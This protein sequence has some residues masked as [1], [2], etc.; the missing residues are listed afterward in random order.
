MIT[1]YENLMDKVI[2]KLEEAV[3]FSKAYDAINDDK[4]Q[5]AYDALTAEE[6]ER[7]DT[8]ADRLYELANKILY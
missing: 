4:L 7:L 2:E 3:V 8:K 5:K 6:Q 1:L